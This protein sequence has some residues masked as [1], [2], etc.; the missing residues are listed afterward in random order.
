MFQAGVETD[1]VGIGFSIDASAYRT[2]L[3]SEQSPGCFWS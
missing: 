1:G 2:V 3:V